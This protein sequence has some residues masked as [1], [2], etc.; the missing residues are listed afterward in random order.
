MKISVIIP[1]L[2]EEK[3]I[4]KLLKELTIPELKENFDYEIIVSDG[5]SKDSTIEI[6]NKFGAKIVLHKSKAKQTI[7][8]GRNRGAEAATGEI[9]IFLNADVRPKNPSKL[10]HTAITQF[11]NSDFLAMTCPVKVFPEEEKFVDKFF[12]GFYNSY[13]G[14]LNLIGLG[15]GRGE[16]QVLRRNDFFEFGK[17]NENLIAGEDFELFKRLRKRGKIFY[18]KNCLVYESPR[19]YRKYGHWKIFFLW[20]SNAL[21]V[22]FANK[23]ASKE[24]E[25]IR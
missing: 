7:A 12:T 8:E 14:L 25:E 9:L 1:T 17:Y 23:S 5:G 19:R 20:L 18:N 4:G 13:F 16:C 21:S 11:Y 22:I 15:M 6:A 3:L 10:F 24:W 2:N